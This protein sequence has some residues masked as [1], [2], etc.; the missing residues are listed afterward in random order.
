[1]N[2]VR[3]YFIG[4]ILK[5]TH[6]VFEHARAIMLLRFC[7][8]YAFIFTL[9]F[10][11]DLIMGYKKLAV[12][13][14]FS[15]ALLMIVP[16]I[17]KAQKNLDRS[18]NL[19][20]SVCTIISAI[21]FMMLNPMVIEPIGACWSM[22]FLVLSA[23]MQRGKVRLL[24]CCFLLWLPIIG[25]LVNIQLKGALTVEWM[26]QEG[27]ETPPIFLMFIPIILCVYAVW[28]HT[29]TVQQAKVTITLQKK[30]IDEKNKDILDSI[31][32][33]KRIQNS[34]LPTDKYIERILDQSAKERNNASICRF[35]INIGMAM[36]TIIFS[37]S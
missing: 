37:G 22:L 20:F 10:I 2:K 8:M 16:W 29:T 25:V 6:D 24:F 30:I 15:L 14:G 23:L 17:I 12:V 34:L 5:S 4:D 27:A 33:A 32:Y 21:I 3:A 7:L 28:T 18:I 9:P 31:H 11:T 1:M 13:H 26:L 36:A 19:F 35:L